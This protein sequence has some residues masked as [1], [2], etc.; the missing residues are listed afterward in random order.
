MTNMPLPPEGTRWARI[1][2]AGTWTAG[3]RAAHEA[4]I[5]EWR[6]SQDYEG[7][8]GPAPV[9]GIGSCVLAD[10]A[11]VEVA[12]LVGPAITYGRRRLHIEPDGSIWAAVPLRRP[13]VFAGEGFV[14]PL[15]GAFRLEIVLDHGVIR[16][17]DPAGRYPVR[18][19]GAG[20]PVPACRIAA[21]PDLRRALAR[22]GWTDPQV[23]ADG[24]V[25]WIP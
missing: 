10:C 20:G 4:E 11:R 14:L 1:A 12:P 21:D 5:A 16:R 7:G 17:C 3:A 9:P 23:L 19:V 18:L 6:E 2:P 24:S 15:V 25:H 8:L 22:V 13:S